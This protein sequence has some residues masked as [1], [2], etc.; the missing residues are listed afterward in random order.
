MRSKITLLA[1][2]FAL[3]TAGVA[4]AQIKKAEVVRNSTEFV[5]K[6]AK[7]VE[8][9]TAFFKNTQVAKS[10]KANADVPAGYV[11]LVVRIEDVWQDGSGY[12]VLF[13][14]ESLAT[15]TTYDE[16]FG[17]ATVTIPEG[18]EW[19]SDGTTDA[20]IVSGVET[21]VIPAGTYGYVVLNPTPGDRTYL[22]K[23]DTYTFV[24]GIDYELHI[25][26]DGG[27]KIEFSMT[28]GSNL[29]T[30]PTDL[31]AAPSETTAEVSWTAGDNNTG[32]NLRYRPY[33]DPTTA[34]RFF[35]F[36]DTEQLAGWL[37]V[38]AD[39]D[40]KAWGVFTDSVGNTMLTSA[41]YDNTGALTPDNWLVTPY[42]QLGGNITFK[43][44]GQDASYAAEV[45]RVYVYVGEQWTSVS[46]FVA[47][48]EDITATGAQ[49]EYTFDLSAYEGVGC[50]AIRHYNV[51]D[52]F[53]LNIDDVTLQTLDDAVIPDWVEVDD[54]VSP[55]VIDGL[56]PETEYEVQVMAYGSEMETDWTE[57]THFTTSALTGITDV[58]A[59]A[60]VVRY[61]DI[62]GRYVGTSIDNVP[63]GL[64]IG[65]NG[66]KVIK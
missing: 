3:L 14:P 25:Y 53:R 54:V 35:D 59:E 33:V 47:I 26:Y 64:Y 61:Y 66:K 2:M 42:F 50:V 58:K 40:S 12:Q 27:E 36:Q 16:V 22:E 18:A 8:T 28:G 38:D 39:G 10:V 43:A 1:M 52:M 34:T 11:Q 20:K 6:T 45:F 55:Y 65:N 57:S 21:V 51:T 9:P 19:A 41:S 49:T 13:G 46:Q 15:A 5:K 37:V 63:A 23:Q 30:V 32:W 60:G 62:S 48:S 24:E 17:G 44:W 7:V 56:T 4:Q 29:V 31:T